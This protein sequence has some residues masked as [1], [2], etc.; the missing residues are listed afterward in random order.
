MYQATGHTIQYKDYTYSLGEFKK[1]GINKFDPYFVYSIGS[2]RHSRVFCNGVFLR[3]D[4]VT[5]YVDHS[6]S[7]KLKVHV[8]SPIILYFG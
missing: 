5:Y 1:N 8:G 3:F 7:S 2:G 6:S 4:R